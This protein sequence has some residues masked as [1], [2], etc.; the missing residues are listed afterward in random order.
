[1]K[2]A[3]FD[4]ELPQELIAQHPPERRDAARMMVLHRPTEG[5]EHRLFTDLAE[6]VRPG[7]VLVLN[8]TRV[9]A[10][11]LFARKQPTGG[12]VELLL[13]KRLNGHR[14]E[15]LVRGRRTRAGT[16]LAVLDGAGQP[17]GPAATVLGE[18]DF[19]GRVVEFESDPAQWLERYGEMPLPP[20]IHE[21]LGDPERY[22]T[23]FAETPGSA[24]APTAGLH[25][26]AAT[27]AGLQRQG[28]RVEYVTLHV[29]LDTFRPVHEEEVERHA[30]HSEWCQLTEEVAERLSAARAEGRGIV[31]VGTTVVRVLETAALRAAEEGAPQAFAPFS[32]ETDIFITPGF[33]FRAVDALLTNFHLPRSTLL[34]LVSA[35]AGREF[36]LRAYREAVAARY[37]FFSFGDCM[38]IL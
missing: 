32:G 12:T 28:V 2:T 33:R 22:Q 10:A 23:V 13:L 31:A 26:T 24:A 15:A 21:R 29:G 37:R 20:Y 8:R 16:R 25:F 30:I 5:I 36:I 27:I 34:M 17:T 1:M 4:Y 7:D 14:W 38:L 18:T 6:H 9:L 11:R 35:F 19:G 3:D